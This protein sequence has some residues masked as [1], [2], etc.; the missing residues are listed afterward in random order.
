MTDQRSVQKITKKTKEGSKRWLRRQ[1]ND[2]YV[3]Q[4]KTLGY[5]SRSAFKLLEIQEKEHIIRPGLHILDLGC[6]PGGWSQIM[7]HIP[8]VSVAG[9]DLLPTEAMPGLD[10][11]QGDFLDPKVQAWI[12]SK[13]PFHGVVSD[14]APS[15][16]G[17]HATDLLRIEHMAEMVWSI[18]KPVLA[19][20]GFFLVKA[21]HTQ[22]IQRL[23]QEWKKE[24]KRVQY[25][26]PK[27]SRKESKEIYIL[28]SCYQ[29]VKSK[30]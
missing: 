25:I 14:A 23:H 10:F 15:S 5:R 27:S 11:L 12:Q 17:H 8:K 18:A 9:V 6:A 20:G 1:L 24:F 16:T 13:G 21:F 19:S 7:T 29:D 4:A 2:P 3:K 26:K 28:A 30:H 22:G